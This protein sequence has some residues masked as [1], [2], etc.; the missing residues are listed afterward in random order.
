MFG[1]GAGVA[2]VGALFLLVAIAELLIALDLLDRWVAYL[3]VGAV[4][5]ISGALVL[6]VGVKRFQEVDP[7][8]HETIDSLR[9]DVS[10]LS[11]QGPSDRT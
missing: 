1:V 5:A 10:W 9:K 4:C 2:A 11:E 3:L 8:P 6:I 7:V